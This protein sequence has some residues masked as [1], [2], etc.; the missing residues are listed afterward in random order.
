MSLIKYSPTFA[1]TL[2]VGF[3][4]LTGCNGS[5]PV[6]PEELIPSDTTG[7]IETR[8]WRSSIVSLPLTPDDIYV[9]FTTALIEENNELHL[10]MTVPEDTLLPTERHSMA[11]LTHRNNQWE[12]EAKV[13]GFG[14]F[15]P[16]TIVSNSLGH[17]YFIWSGVREELREVPKTWN[18]SDVFFCIWQNGA[19]SQPK[20]L[21]QG[22]TPQY[23]D[24][25]SASIDAADNIF[26]PF[27]YS[28]DTNIIELSGQDNTVEA[29]PGGDSYP[30][31]YLDDGTQYLIS[32]GVPNPSVGSNDVYLAS[33]KQDSGWINRRVIFH[34]P[35]RK[36]HHPAIVIDDAENF[37]VA[38]Y[39]QH[40]DGVMDI[41]HQLST[42]N[43][44]TWSDT[45]LFSEK[46]LFASPP[47]LA[48]DNDGA[49]H[50]VW[51]LFEELPFRKIY[52]AVW[53]NGNWSA[54]ERLFP[55]K[56]IMQRS[57]MVADTQNRI[58]LVFL[59]DRQL[60]HATFE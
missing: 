39:A 40:P 58:H 50:L 35:A 25:Y 52:H 2:F 12:I 33:R 32:V 49:V 53:R 54:S 31:L 38:F 26:L 8:S 37:H 60:H 24:F 20:S 51:E 30:R 23:L 43:G 14:V 15:Y 11:Y 9:S 45:L 46:N 29:I 10:L 7:F 28:L 59:A 3:L 57:F 41:V 18:G 42:D 21:F 16:A 47:Q 13:E 4:S 19:C 55:N 27:S 1:L 48:V 17:K 6:E 5:L 34:D 44:I 36:G 22:T 56:K